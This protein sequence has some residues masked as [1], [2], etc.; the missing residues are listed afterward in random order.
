MTDRPLMLSDI[1][2]IAAEVARLTRNIERAGVDIAA[3]VADG[4]L[5]VKQKARMVE[6]MAELRKDQKTKNRRAA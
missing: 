3:E 4:T 1:P 2:A 6:V 5:A